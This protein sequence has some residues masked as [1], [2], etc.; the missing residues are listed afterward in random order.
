[1]PKLSDLKNK[2]A[3]PVIQYL[4]KLIL[5]PDYKDWVFLSYREISKELKK[6]YNFQAGKTSLKD[7]IKSKENTFCYVKALNPSRSIYGLEKNVLKYLEMM[8]NTDAK[9]K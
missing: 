7:I 8:E 3:F 2:K 5:H 1:L 4:R 6:M 9:L